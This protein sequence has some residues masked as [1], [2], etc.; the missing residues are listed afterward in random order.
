MQ[1]TELKIFIFQSDISGI[2]WDKTP[3]GLHGEGEKLNLS[4][5]PP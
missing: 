3:I 5:E 2:Q 1:K 4:D